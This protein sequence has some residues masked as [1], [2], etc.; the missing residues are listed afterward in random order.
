MKKTLILIAAACLL[1]GSAM[2][3][4]VDRATAH[5]VAVAHW[6]TYRPQDVKPVDSLRTLTF[7]ELQH[8]YV[9]ANDGDGFVIVA[10]DDRVRPILGYSFDS[11]FPTRLHRELRFW[12]SIYDDQIATAIRGP[13]TAADPRWAALVEGEVPNT[14]VALQY[15]QP[16]CRTRWDQGDPFNRLCPFD[17]IYNTRA[18]VGCVATAMAQ[19]MKRWNH[20]WNGEGS[21][22]YV[23]QPM[24]NTPS[25]GTLSAD[26]GNSTYR[27]D[28][29][30]NYINMATSDERANALSLISYHCGVSVDMMYGTSATGGSGA[31]SSSCVGAFRDHFRYNADM[32]YLN[33]N[34]T[35]WRDSTA[36]VNGVPQTVHYTIDTLLIPDSIWLGLIDS[37]LANGWPIYYDGSDDDGGHAFVLDG[38]NIDT[39]YHFN[40]GWSG[41]GDG[42]YAMNNLA[43][44]SGGIGGNVT[45]TFNQWQG[46]IFGIRP[47]EEV[48]VETDLYDTACIGQSQYHIYDY[49]L[50]VANCD[51][52]L[53]HLDTLIYLH[54]RTIP[55]STLIYSAAR[56]NFGP[57]FDTTYCPTEE[58]T[59]RECEFTR[60]NCRF[61]GWCTKKNA[62]ADD[63]IF[64]PGD[65]V[66][67]HGNVTLYAQWVDTTIV[68]IALPD[69]ASVSLSPNPTTGMVN[70]K[71]DGAQRANIL[72]MDALGRILMNRTDVAAGADAIVIDLSALPSGIYT[73]QVRTPEATCNKRI[74]KR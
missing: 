17:S 72:V 34:R 74:I 19:I 50:P 60:E 35:L 2:A 24:G 13:H 56:G 22:S 28:I 69:D 37:N 54:L 36:T 18:V 41:Y 30:P 3:A 48:F 38:S 66:R 15:V 71:I 68:G 59:I 73:L 47:A 6:N 52:H 53:H 14:P 58:V 21:H 70:L 61:T 5:R 45:Y 29:M 65:R 67:L 33:R 1:A 62:G 57:Q 42:F 63:H 16:L 20:P 10:A 26:F 23:H 46:A 9:F 64:Q 55:T 32:Q 4:P 11:P 27:W 43:P 12:L 8:M 44:G 31:Y 51:T 49:T 25:Y 7:G 39:T 40:W